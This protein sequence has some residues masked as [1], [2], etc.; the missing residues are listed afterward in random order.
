[1]KDR[2]QPVIVEATFDAPITK[3]W[4]A[5]TDRDEMIQWYFDNIPDFKP[6]VGF[7]TAFNV[8][9]ESRDFYHQWEVTEVEPLKKLVYQ[10]SFKDIPGKSPSIWELEVVNDEVL[11]RLTATGLDKF[12][13]D[14][15]E[16]TWESCF[17][18]WNYF[19]K[20]RLKNYLSA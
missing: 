1:M 16:F 4:K 10:W 5:I 14:I 8:K 9:A 7:K 3:V 19:L 20:E 15:P 6:E 12:P 18:G 17:G 11:L 2:S 13:A